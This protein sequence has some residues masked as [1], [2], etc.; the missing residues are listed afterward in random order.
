MIRENF[1]VIDLFLILIKSIGSRLYGVL[2]SKKSDVNSL[3]N[4]YI[5]NAPLKNINKKDL[6]FLIKPWIT[7]G[8]Q[9]SVKSK[10]NI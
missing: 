6:K 3:M 7:L 9:N 5:S 8:L 1:K 2:W 10:N 4:Q